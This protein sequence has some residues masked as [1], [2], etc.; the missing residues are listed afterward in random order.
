[1][2]GALFH[3]VENE[4]VVVHVAGGVGTASTMGENQN[5][6]CWTKTATI[7]RDSSTG[8]GRIHHDHNHR[9]PD[10]I[11]EQASTSKRPR[12][13]PEP[14]QSPP[15]KR[16]R[17]SRVPGTTE[18][19]TSYDAC[20]M[21]GVADYFYEDLMPKAPELCQL[22]PTLCHDA[23]VVRRWLGP[24]G[25]AVYWTMVTED[26]NRITNTSNPS[27]PLAA[28]IARSLTKPRGPQWKASSPKFHALCEAIRSHLGRGDARAIVVF[29]GFQQ[30]ELS[31]EAN[32]EQCVMT[33][34]HGFPC[35]C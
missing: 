13:A 29:S 4:G 10:V 35:G 9:M 25:C 3:F 2:C 17:S 7:D 24:A 15:L 18:S 31:L 21:P 20:P 23:Y 1:M 27:H 8:L 28:L 12:D 30:L 33:Q 14:H 5:P 32:P 22:F 34:L 19:T 26:I 11:G 16:F 6:P